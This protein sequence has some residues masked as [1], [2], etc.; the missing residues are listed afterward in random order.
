MLSYIHFL[1]YKNKLQDLYSPPHLRQIGTFG[2]FSFAISTSILIYFTVIEIMEK[3]RM[4]LLHK[5]KFNF[6]NRYNFQ[7]SCQFMTAPLFP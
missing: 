7:Q 3:K 2:F 5:L 4:K 1:N 6:L